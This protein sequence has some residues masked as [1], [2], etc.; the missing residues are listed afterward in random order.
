MFLASVGGGGVDYRFQAK[1]FTLCSKVGLRFRVK[2][3]RSLG[4]RHQ[5]YLRVG[6]VLSLKRTP[7]PILLIN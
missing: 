1:G 5:P 6:F 7:K 3:F 4:L 2:K